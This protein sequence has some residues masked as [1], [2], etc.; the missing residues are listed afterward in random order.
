MAIARPFAYN[1]GISIPGTEQLGDLSIGYPTTGFTDSPQYWNGPDEELGYIICIPVSGN[2]QPTPLS[3]V[4]A[5]VGFYRSSALTESSFVILTNQVFKQN[6]IDGVDA[7]EYLNDN[8]YWTSYESGLLVKLDSGNSSSYSGAGSTW[9][10]LSGNFNN[11]T[12]I[13][14]PTYSSAYSGILQFDDASLEY[15]TIPNIGDLSNWTVEVWFRLTSPLTGKITAIATNQFNLINKLNFSIGTN[16]APTNRNIASGF[17]DSSGWHTTA[18]VVPPTNTWIQVVGTYDGTVIRQYVNGVASGGTLPYVGVPQSGGEIRLMRRW[19]EPLTS[20]NFV[21]GDLVIVKIYNIALTNEDVLFNYNN[22]YTRFLDITPTP[23]RTP[24][25]TPTNTPSQTETSTPTVTPTQTVTPTN[26]ETPT[27]TP[28]QT[29]TST[30]TV[31]PTMTAT[32]SQTATQTATVTPTMT[33]TPSQTATQTATVTPTMTATQTPTPS[34]TQTPTPSNTQTP[35]PSITASQTQTPTPS[36]TASQTQTPTPSITASPTQTPTPSITASPTQTPTPSITASP[37][38]TPTPS[39]TASPSQTPTPSITASPTRTP[40]PSI[41]ASQTQTPTASITASQTQ[42]PTPSNTQ[43]PTPSNTQTP[44]PSNTQT[45]TPSNT[46]TPTPTSTPT[47]FTALI[48]CTDS[49]NVGW[50]SDT[51]ACQGI[52]NQRTVY[53][54]QVGVTSFQQAAVTFGLPLYNNTNFTPANLYNGNNQWFKSVGGGEV[55]RVGTDGAMSQF[56]ACPSATPTPTRTPTQTPTVSLSSTPP[57]TPTQTPTNTRTQTP[58]KSPI[59]SSTTWDVVIAQ[60]DLDDATGN[61]DPGKNDGTVYVDYIASDGTPTTVQ[62]GFASSYTICVKLFAS[63][64]PT[65][66]YYKDNLQTAPSGSSLT[67]TS[68]PC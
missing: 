42:T 33:A 27:T 44:T 29:E 60:I 66:Y 22:T 5:S 1:P 30:P 12:L 56:G 55:F 8:G 31:T 57:V 11:A 15:A 36:I 23:T 21:D 34:N 37:S 38:Q 19:D 4:T 64:S 46:Q 50:N 68:V 35:T 28:S 32:P 61:T 26:T 43:T 51:A 58:T 41:T 6:F 54:P 16:N 18:G 67:D 13:N 52:C 62:Y 65:I 17:F 45:P 3:G 2:T 47:N 49:G 7:K 63:P 10:D 24:T 39:I 48:L 59:P 20:S 14:S 40:T 25:S 53:V 9:F